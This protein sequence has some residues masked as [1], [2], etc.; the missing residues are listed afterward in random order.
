MALDLVD[1]TPPAP[2]DG[3][4]HRTRQ[5]SGRTGHLA[6]LAAEDCVEQDYLRRGYPALSRRWRGQGG[7]IDLVV[8]DGDGVVIVEVKKSRSFSRAMDRLSQRQIARL[9]A[10]AEEYVGTMPRGS[11]TDIRFDVALVNDRGEIRIVENALA[12]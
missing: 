9:C 10:A 6:G 7:E 3:Q 1:G 12:C 2:G 8:Q 5:L 4:Q 11:L